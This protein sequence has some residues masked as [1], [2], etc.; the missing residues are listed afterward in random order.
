MLTDPSGL[1]PQ[2]VDD[3]AGYLGDG[4]EV[5][6]EGALNFAGGLADELSGGL[7]G[8]VPLW[9]EYPTFGVGCLPGDPGAT[10]LGDV[11][12]EKSAHYGWGGDASWAVPFTGVLKG[13]RLAAK[14][15]ASR[16][17]NAQATDLAGWLGFRSTGRHLRRERVFT[18]GKRFIVQDTTSHTGGMWKMAKTDKA[19]GSRTTRTGTYDEQLNY[20]GP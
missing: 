6:G 14:A 5:V 17:T 19:L 3:A 11:V 18:D 8:E 7:A 16:L 4:A 9:C 2:W 10:T 12:D 20:I 13:A 15:G 1:T